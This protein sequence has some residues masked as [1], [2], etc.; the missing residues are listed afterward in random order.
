MS[1][2]QFGVPK[3]WLLWRETSS[4]GTQTSTMGQ[5]LMGRRKGSKNKLFLGRSEGRS[6]EET[7][8][9]KQ[10]RSSSSMQPAH[11]GSSF[12][13]QNVKRGKQPTTTRRR[14]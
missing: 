6:T 12:R 9:M 13:L 4:F 2:G 1:E 7:V 3:P 5:G 8:A 10:N 14:L 11:F